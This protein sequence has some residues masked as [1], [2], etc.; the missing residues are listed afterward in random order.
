MRIDK[1]ISGELYYLYVHFIP[2]ERKASVK[3][4]HTD[5]WVICDITEDFNFVILPNNHF[6]VNETF[7]KRLKLNKVQ[8]LD[9]IDYY[10]C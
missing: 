10:N 9:A 5:E 8:R 3:Y 4:F 6:K 2:K 1:T 7:I